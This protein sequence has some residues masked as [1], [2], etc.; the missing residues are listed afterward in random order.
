MPG[1]VRCLY[2]QTCL[3]LRYE[4]H[5][6]NPLPAVRVEPGM[7][8]TSELCESNPVEVYPPNLTHTVWYT[9]FPLKKLF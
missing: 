9:P 3:F 4:H 1:V 7:H 8:G 6:M 2:P 5:E